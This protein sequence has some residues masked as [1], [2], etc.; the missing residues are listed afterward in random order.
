MPQSRSNTN[1]W[2]YNSNTEA[3]ISNTIRVEYDDAEISSLT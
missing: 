2:G 1:L 3:Q